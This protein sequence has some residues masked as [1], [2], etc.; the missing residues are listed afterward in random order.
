MDAFL[1]VVGWIGA[2]VMGLLVWNLFPETRAIIT[3]GIA[4]AF[5]CYVL[6]I[7]VGVTVKRLM[8]DEL[9]ELRLQSNVV[10]DRLD[11]MDRKITAI[12][13]DS[14]ELR[15]A[16]SLRAS[17][18]HDLRQVRPE[19]GTACSPSAPK[20]GDTRKVQSKG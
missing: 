19:A 12:L 15:Q 7:V 6:F 16:A 13:R 1:K 5:I 11:L 2:T 4:L 18:S 17:M 20:V 10:A 8:G 3:C 14:L 9:R